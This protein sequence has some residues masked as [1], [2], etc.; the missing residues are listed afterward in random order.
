MAAVLAVI[1]V[2]CAPSP[3]PP[4]TP[5]DE[6]LGQPLTDVL[7]TVPQEAALFIQDVSPRVD[8]AASY[9]EGSDPAAWTVVAVCADAADLRAVVSVEVAV[10]PRGSLDAVGDTDDR[11]DGAVECSGRPHGAHL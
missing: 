8:L 11:F 3:P 1:L 6:L 2:G 4:P 5:L 9:Q 7:E 10:V